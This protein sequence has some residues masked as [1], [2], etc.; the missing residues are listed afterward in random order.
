MQSIVWPVILLL[1][2]SII[3]NSF[4]H[5]V[6]SQERALNIGLLVMATGKYTC[7]LEK[8]LTSADTYFLPNH[9]RVYF[10]FTDGE[11]PVLDNVI[12][13]E[14]KR[15]GWPYDTLMR[16]SVYMGVQSCFADIDYLFACDA[17]MFFVDIVGDEILSE[18]VATNHPGFTLPEQ[19]H[20]DYE[21]NSQSCAYVGP[22]EGQAY[23]AGG[24]FGGSTAEFIKIATTCNEHIMADLANNIIAEWHDESHLNRY[25]IDNPPTVILSPSYCYPQYW[26][27]PFIPRLV[28]V[29][30][31]HKQ[32]QI[33]G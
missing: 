18:R 27:L 25:F 4:C 26:D 6:V 14:Q 31:D 7:F 19:R 13:I 1:L 32:F 8:L 21:H 3:Y 29:S 5:T 30:K 15:L 10:I 33:A 9:N 16:F 28:A 2:N 22:G 12:R 11:V 24:F 17:D 20:N 23:F